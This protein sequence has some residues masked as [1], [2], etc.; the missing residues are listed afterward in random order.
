MKLNSTDAINMAQQPQ[1]T[2]M[3]LNDG[4]I[5]KS[6]TQLSELEKATLPVSEKIVADAIQKVN[7]TME[8][9]AHTA[10]RYSV[11]DKTNTIIVKVIDKDTNEVLREIPP[12]KM[13]DLV[14]SL[15][16]L[17]GIMIDERR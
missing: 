10:L 6:V 15:M 1:I 11:H 14:A 16:E 12:E 3:R 5:N 4:M 13:L 8:S 9:F 7:R 2:G 17:S